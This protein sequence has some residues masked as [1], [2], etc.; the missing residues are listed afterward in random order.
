MR[1]NGKGSELRNIQLHRIKCTKLI[2][3]VISPAL[4]EALKKDVKNKK[5]FVL[6]DESSDLA[7]K[8]HVCVIIRY[9]SESK[10]KLA[11]EF[12]GLVPVVGATGSDIFLSLSTVLEKI[13]LT[14]SDCVRFASDGAS[15]LRR[16]HNSVWS[17][18]TQQWPDCQLNKCVCHLLSL[19]V[20]KAFDK[21]PLSL[22][23]LLH[24]IP[25]WFSNSIICKAYKELFL[26]MDP[27]E[28]RRGTPVPFQKISN[29]RWLVRGKA[30]FNILVNWEELQVCITAALPVADAS[31]CYK[32]REI[33][34]MLKS[35]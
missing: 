13:G 35:C 5:F 33:L 18:V 26:T 15:S 22:G 2:S 14:L 7:V 11:T 10:S 28:E 29:T 4:F 24:E 9:F 21:P 27:N 19:C 34:S 6:L 25:K 16:E 20:E 23:H 31:C 32:A 1:K 30:L 8:K 3:K 17:R 12:A